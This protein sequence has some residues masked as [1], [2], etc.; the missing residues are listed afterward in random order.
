MKNYNIPCVYFFRDSNN[1]LLYIG[2]TNNLESRYEN[3]LKDNKSWRSVIHS[4]EYLEIPNITDREILET[5]CINKFNPLFN[6]DKVYGEESSLDID[7]PELQKIIV[8]DKNGLCTPPFGRQN[9][10]QLFEYLFEMPSDKINYELTQNMINQKETNTKR[11][12]KILNKKEWLE[13]KDNF[14]GHIENYKK[15]YITFQKGKFIFNKS[16]KTY[17]EILCKYIRDIGNLTTI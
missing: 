1:T 10:F 2:K 17:D 7:L 15:N 6:I 14:V 8:Y 16:W 5:Y 11:I 9:L 12:I 4:I 13:I 3:H